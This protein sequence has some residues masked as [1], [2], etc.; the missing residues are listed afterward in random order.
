VIFTDLAAGA[1]VFLD[2]N[3]LVYHFSGDAQLGAPC[4]ELIKRIEQQDVPGFTSTHVLLDVAHRLMTIEAI[5]V[6]GWPVASIAQRLRRHHQEIPRLTR[7][8]QAVD[9]VPKLNI[10][11]LPVLPPQVSAAAALCQQCEL[12][13]GDALVV[14]VMQANGLTNLASHDS[15]FD[16]VR[17]LTR[18]APV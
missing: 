9:E 16:R 8:R 14:A 3:T 17:G 1:A 18:Y 12:L 10:Q 13:S 2:A 5:L 15:D 11:V 4:T 6:F 7:F